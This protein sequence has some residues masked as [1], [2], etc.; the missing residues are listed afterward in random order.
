MV[1]A[2]ESCVALEDEGEC[3]K[4]EDMVVV[5]NGKAQ[6]LSTYPFEENLLS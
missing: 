2:I 4:L 3:V 1:M 6:L 5:T